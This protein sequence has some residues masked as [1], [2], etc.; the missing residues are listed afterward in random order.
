MKQFK[1][2]NILDKVF[3]KCVFKTVEIPAFDGNNSAWTQ[4]CKCG[5]K[6]N[7]PL[8]I[9]SECVDITKCS[10]KTVDK[11]VSNEK[12]EVWTQMCKCGKKQEVIF[13]IKGKCRGIN[14]L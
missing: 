2:S 11:P 13:D 12:G 5:K 3:H 1:I 4:V 10:F 6:Q 7:V 9:K 8:E 14:Y